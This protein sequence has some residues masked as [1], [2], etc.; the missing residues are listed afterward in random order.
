MRAL[1]VA[2]HRYLSD[3]IGSYFS[4]LG[5][6]CACVV[7]I[8][9]ALE[10]GRRQKPDMVICEYDLLVLAALERWETDATLARIPL[11][12]VSLSR[13]SDEFHLLDRNC[14]A[15]SLYLPTLSEADARRVLSGLVRT[16]YTLPS[17]IDRERPSSSSVR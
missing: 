13:R 7:G 9:E 17:T 4:G 5:V 8:D 11:L 2:R 14:I 1:C 16:R 10:A 6:E 12:A 15:G 3:H